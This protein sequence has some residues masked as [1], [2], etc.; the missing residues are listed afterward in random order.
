MLLQN[1]SIHQSHQQK[2][3]ANVIRSTITSRMSKVAFHNSRLLNKSKENG[4]LPT[5]NKIRLGKSKKYLEQFI[6]ESKKDT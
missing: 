2:I 3:I 6:K 4:V 1:F 5:N